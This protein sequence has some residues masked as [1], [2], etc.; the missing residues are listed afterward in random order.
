MGHSSK[1]LAASHYQVY[2][3]TLQS[4]ES[5]N[6]IIIFYGVGMIWK[7]FPKKICVSETLD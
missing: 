3:V 4:I 2:L 1:S 7:P 5:G 6:G